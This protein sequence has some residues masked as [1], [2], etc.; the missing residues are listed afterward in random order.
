MLR[1]HAKGNLVASSACVGGYLAKIVFSNQDQNVSWDDWSPS[2]YNFELIQRELK[3]AAEKFV[4]VLGGDSENY[5]LELQF[6]KLNPQHLVNYHLIEL[7][8]RTG[9]K[10]VATAD[11]HYAR[12]DTWREREI[13][14]AMAWASKS[15]TKTFDANK[16]PQ[17][18]ADLK[19]ELFPKNAQQMWDEYKATFTRHPEYASFYDDQLVKDA[20]ERTHDIAHNLIGSLAIDSKVKLPSVSTLVPEKAL[21]RIVERSGVGSVKDLDEDDVAFKHLVQLGIDG[22]RWRKRNTD[23]VYI[24][25]LK[26]ELDTIKHLKFSKYFLTYY[27]V[28]RL[29]SEHMMIGAGR[30]SAAGSLLSY[31][32][33]I[34]QVDPI[35]F[36][37]LFE[38]FLVKSKKCLPPNTFVATTEGPKQLGD[39]TPGMNVLT[40]TNTYKPVVSKEYTDHS[41][42]VEFELEDGTVLTS[43]PNHLW[44]VVRDG[45][46]QEIVASDIRE[47]DEFIEKL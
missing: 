36:G 5:Y 20:I 24:E 15:K 42:V 8:K 14:K 6:N 27:N 30:G 40:H 13:Y 9:L 18:I 2:T 38:R 11:S 21:E 44:V 32:L 7:S 22:L 46:R 29:A 28:M 35:R 25:R 47:T 19:C 10:L 31:V 34:T 37:L 16:L 3:E 39:I 1:R 33:G 12:P 26:Y 41:E 43:S 4:D 17:T 23:D 45:K